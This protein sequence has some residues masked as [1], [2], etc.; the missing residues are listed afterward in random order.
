MKVLLAALLVNALHAPLENAEEA[1]NGVGVDFA[2]A[3]FAPVVV[4]HLMLGGPPSGDVNG[5]AQSAI[6][7]A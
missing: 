2:P 1:L 4:N 6:I 5:V 7:Q 3:I